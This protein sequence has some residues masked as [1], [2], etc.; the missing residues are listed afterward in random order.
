MYEEAKWFDN[1]C[2]ERK[3]EY[4]DAIRL[5]NANRSAANRVLLCEKKVVYNNTVR[6]KKR[7]YNHKKI[8]TIKNFKGKKPKHFWKLFSKAK[9]EA[10]GDITAE[11]FYVFFKNLVDEINVVQ[12]EE[13]ENFCE[14][15]NF[16]GDDAIFEELDAN[17]TES[18]V[19]ACIKKLKRDKS[20]GS[21]S[22]LNEYFLEARDILLSHLTEIFNVILDSGHFPESWLDGVI[23]PLSKKVIKWM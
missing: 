3:T 22:L 17:I 2:R 19:K 12:N 13:P 23:I 1:E 14:N 18:E 6:Q 10:S 4:I 11:G 5:F 20:C 7:V 9:S 8:K 21:D 15:D 16:N